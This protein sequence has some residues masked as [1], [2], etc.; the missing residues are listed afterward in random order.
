VTSGFV[1]LEILLFPE[2]EPFSFCD[3]ESELFVVLTKVTLYSSISIEPKLLTIET[4]IEKS[5][6]NYFYKIFHMLYQLFI[7]EKIENAAPLLV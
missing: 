4:D 2:L 6:Y 1:F 5:Q 7:F 3:I